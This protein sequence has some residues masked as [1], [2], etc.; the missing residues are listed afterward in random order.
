MVAA[1]LYLDE[2]DRSLSGAW[3]L[4]PERESWVLA[5]ENRATGYYRIHLRTIR[6]PL[7]LVKV[8]RTGP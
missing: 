3:H 5:N 4:L 6:T 2:H 1:P 8:M 7:D